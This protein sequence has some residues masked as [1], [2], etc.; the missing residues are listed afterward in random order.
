MTEG[1]PPGEASQDP[2]AGT[3]TGDPLTRP[4]ALQPCRVGALAGCG[5]ALLHVRLTNAGRGY[6]G[7]A[8]SGATCRPGWGRPLRGSAR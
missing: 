1:W 6:G 4:S 2:G 3:G 7:R 5:E 8:G